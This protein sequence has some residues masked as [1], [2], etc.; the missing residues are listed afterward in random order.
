MKRELAALTVIIML[1]V[2]SI[3]N[4]RQIDMLTDEISIAICKSK[5]AAE[6]LNF[7]NSKR[8]IE[9]GLEIWQESQTHT[10]AFMPQTQLDETTLAFYQLIES[11]NQEDILSLI[12][13]YDALQF[14]MDS[15]RDGERLSI[16][17]IF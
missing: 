14:R 12:P 3:W 13:A 5:T 15:I 10:M 17:S 4:I 2:A 11:I 9:E 6:Q 16:G 1:I 8:Y 7:K